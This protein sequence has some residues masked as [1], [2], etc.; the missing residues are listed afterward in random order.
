MMA[1]ERLLHGN[2]RFVA[3]TPEHPGQDAAQRSQLS[4]G[5]EPY[6]MIFGC[7]DSRVAAE[8]IFDQGLGDLFVVRT[9]GHVVDSAVLGSCEFGVS[10]LRIPL[11]VVLGHDRCGAVASTVTALGQTGMPRG[12][13]RDIVERVSPSVVAARREAHPEPPT[14][15]EIER[16]HVRQTVALLLERSTVL[17]TAVRVGQCAVIGATYELEQGRVRAVTPAG[18]RA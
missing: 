8:I 16:E 17:D 7:S 4:G 2:E 12:F 1:W 13:V 6:A 15:E 14:V 9:A 5:Q 11:V 3:G 10:T 18:V